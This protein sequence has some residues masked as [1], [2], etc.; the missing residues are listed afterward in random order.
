MPC[1]RAGHLKHRGPASAR[2]H[3][4]AACA[5]DALDACQ[6]AISNHVAA[7]TKGNLRS[8][9]AKLRIAA[10]PQVLLQMDGSYWV[11]E[12]SKLQPNASVTQM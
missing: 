3:P 12:F 4:K 7:R 2:A 5:A 1:Q 11:A 9:A 6:P 10:M 8:Q